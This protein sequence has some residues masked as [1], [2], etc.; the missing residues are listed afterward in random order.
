[1]GNL[2]A[3]SLFNPL[4]AI[5]HWCFT[6]F[7][8]YEPKGRGDWEELGWIDIKPNMHH[9]SLPIDLVCCVVFFL[10]VQVGDPSNDNNVTCRI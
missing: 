8:T 3:N 7:M 1:M 9:K 10:I 4:V 2:C 5:L 6:S